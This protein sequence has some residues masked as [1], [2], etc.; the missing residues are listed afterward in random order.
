MAVREYITLE[1]AG[2]RLPG[3]VSTC[4]IWRW[5]TKGFYVPAA[6]QV[7]RMRFVQIGPK[8]FTTE[9]WLEQFIDDFTAAKNLQREA[10][11]RTPGKLERILELY[12][13]DAVLR[14]AGI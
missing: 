7:I 9:L 1:E 4:T 13:A 14:E 5:C 10:K 8:M 11:R 3:S 12:R 6:K 2:R